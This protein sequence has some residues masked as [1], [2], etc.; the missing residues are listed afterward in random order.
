MS[1]LEELD[2]AIAEWKNLL[3]HLGPKLGRIPQVAN[4]QRTK[5]REKQFQGKVC[6]FWDTEALKRLAGRVERKEQKPQASASGCFPWRKQ[7]RG[8]WFAS[9]PRS[10]TEGKERKRQATPEWEMAGLIS[11]GTYL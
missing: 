7:R 3:N 8:C 11:K 1:N 2:L 6:F 4:I 9:C 10:D 5:G